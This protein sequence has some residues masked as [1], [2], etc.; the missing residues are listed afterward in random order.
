MIA[1]HSVGVVLEARDGSRLHVSYNPHTSECER[2]PLPVEPG[3]FAP[4]SRVAKDKPLG[5]SRVPRVLK[6]QLGLSCNYAC[7][8][9]SQAFQIADATVSKLA[10]VEQFLTQLDGWIADAP[11]KIELWGG[12]PFLYWAKIK[13]LIPALAERFPAARFLI[14]TNGS[15]L[16]REKLD[17][18]A[19]HN[20]A[21]TISHDGP[22]QHLRGPDPLDDPDK[23]RWID[24]RMIE[25]LW[26]SLKYECVFLNAFETGLEA[27]QGIGTWIAYYNEERPH[28]SHGLMTP[29]EVYANRKP[30]MKL[31]A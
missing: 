31:A 14:V 3:I 2:L 4:V 27:R 26:R 7:S 9:C 12:E 11:E 29:D 23:R 10:D 16:S 20:I 13:R 19:V 5:K 17:F 15:L 28:S 18:I 6:I 22:G 1:D 21:I 30:N 24:N 25:R 8:Y